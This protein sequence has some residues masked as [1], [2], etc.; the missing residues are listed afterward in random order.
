M[1]PDLEKS[2]FKFFPEITLKTVGNTHW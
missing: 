1:V 2:H